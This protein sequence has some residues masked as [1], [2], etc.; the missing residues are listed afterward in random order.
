MTS[1][2]KKT[3]SGVRQTYATIFQICFERADGSIGWL[4]SNTQHPSDETRR[5]LGIDCILFV[6]EQEV[7]VNNGQYVAMNEQV[8]NY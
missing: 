2:T 4:R 7:L 5:T 1:Y 8:F 3:K 6:D